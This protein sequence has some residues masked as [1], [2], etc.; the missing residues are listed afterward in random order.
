M[1]LAADDVPAHASREGRD[2]G[3]AMGPGSGSHAHPSHATRAVSVGVYAHP[4]AARRARRGHREH[5]PGF[6]GGVRDTSV[7]GGLVHARRF[8]PRRVTSNNSARRRLR[9]GLGFPFWLCRNST[10]S[11]GL[12]V[13][14]A[15]APRGSPFPFLNPPPL[16]RRIHRTRSA[17]SR[18]PFAGKLAAH[19]MYRH[20]ELCVVAAN[21]CNP[22]SNTRCDWDEG[23]V[24]I[25]SASVG[26]L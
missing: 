21:A 22:F 23:R 20:N 12:G 4:P 14:P 2:H 25:A 5:G 11:V 16:A 24:R 26:V 8:V 19:L 10:S 7:R 3:D 13:F 18:T 6:G 17:T 1:H 15:P 9:L